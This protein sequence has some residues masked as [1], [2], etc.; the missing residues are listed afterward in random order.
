MFIASSRGVF[1]G[2]GSPEHEHHL[3]NHRS[4]RELFLGLRNCTRVSPRISGAPALDELAWP[5][6][7]LQRVHSAR[8]RQECVAGFA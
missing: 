7:V 8:F 2:V 1:F 3:Q 4:K 6:G 5:W